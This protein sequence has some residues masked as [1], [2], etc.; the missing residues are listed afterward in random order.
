MPY[1]MADFRRDYVKE[2]LQELSPEERLEGLSL[3]ERLKGLSVGEIE[4]CLRR[5]LAE[6]P[7]APAEAGRSR[8]DSHPYQRSA[9]ATALLDQILEA[10][11]REGIVVPS[12]PHA[13][14]R[15]EYVKEHLSQLTPE[16]RAQGVPAEERLKGLSEGE[17]EEYLTRVQ[18]GYSHLFL[19]QE[20]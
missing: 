1:I 18:K 5:R 13:T 3:E 2:H 12:T 7:P 9:D 16:E 10:Y 11:A 20:E 4:E 19:S 8:P 6:S 15:Q 17:I 14:F